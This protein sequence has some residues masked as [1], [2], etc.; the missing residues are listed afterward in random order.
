MER[1]NGQYCRTFELVFDWRGIPVV[2]QC[3]A[4]AGRQRVRTGPPDE[5]VAAAPPGRG[6]ARP[7]P[8]VCNFAIC[9][10]HDLFAC[11]FIIKKNHGSGEDLL[12]DPKRGIIGSGPKRLAVNAAL[13]K[14]SKSGTE[15]AF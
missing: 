10:K 4:G 9:T 2:L 3:A 1:R 7:G 13:H 8:G 11:F 15:P 14:K 12:P 6:V 5:Q